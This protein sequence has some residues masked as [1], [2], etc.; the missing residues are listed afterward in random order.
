MGAATI[1]LIPARQRFH[2]SSRRQTFSLAAFDA[3]TMA[4]VVFLWHPPAFALDILG[5]TDTGRATASLLNMN[6]R[7]RVQ[8][9]EQLRIVL[10]AP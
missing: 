8:L 2:L 7:R 9:R 1:S 3:V 5:L 10:S 4:V 6:A